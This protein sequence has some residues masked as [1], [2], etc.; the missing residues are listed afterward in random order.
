[1]SS[2]TATILER[3]AATLEREAIRFP[4]PMGDREHLE[5]IGFVFD[6]SNPHGITCPVVLPKGARVEVD[7]RDSRHSYI[8]V[9]DIKV[10]HS[11]YKNSGYDH[12]G[13][14][15]IYQLTKYQLETLRANAE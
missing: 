6:L 5:E 15:N 1:M 3:H 12:Y 14:L 11:F 2:D 8:F 13:Y 4:N 9:G 10:A 7:P